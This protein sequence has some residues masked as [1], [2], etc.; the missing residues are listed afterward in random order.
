MKRFVLPLLLLALVPAAPIAAQ[1]HMHDEQ[2]AHEHMEGHDAAV[3]G[4]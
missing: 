4:D 3:R 1:E 2:E